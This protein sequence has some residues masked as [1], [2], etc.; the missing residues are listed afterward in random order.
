MIKISSFDFK[1]SCVLVSYD[2]ISF[3]TN[4]PLS[5]TIDIVCNYLYQQHSTPKYSKE[6]F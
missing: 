4:V 1:P 5:E 3:S 6:T 2:V